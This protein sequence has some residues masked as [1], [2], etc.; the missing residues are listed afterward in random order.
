LAVNIF[1]LPTRKETRFT[2]KTRRR[3][4]KLR[5]EIV[6]SRQKKLLPARSALS[7]L[8][9]APSRLSGEPFFLAHRATAQLSR[10]SPRA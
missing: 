10:N 5:N 7:A 8:F 4:E 9:F 3:E 6:D 1:F 2:A